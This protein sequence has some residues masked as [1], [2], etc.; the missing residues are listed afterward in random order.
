MSLSVEDILAPGGLVAEHLDNYESRPEQLEMACAVASAFAD[1]EHLL[2]EA[3]TGVGKSFAYLA[4]AILQATA[5]TKRRVVVSTYTIALQEQLITKDLPFLSEIYPKKF[6]AVLG[7]G[8][9]NY[10]CVRRLQRTIAAREKLLASRRHQEQLDDLAE[11]A[12]E[13][14]SGSLQDIE[15]PL[16]RSVWSRCRAE[17][18]LCRNTQCER[19]ENCFFRAARRRMQGADVLVVNHALFFSDL[20]LQA[21]AARM[22]GKYDLVVLDEAHT[23]EQVAGDHFGSSISSSTVNFLL[24][25][26]YNDRTN[27]GTLAAIGDADSIQAVNRASVAAEAFFE[28]LADAR[29]RD[30]S[31]SGRIRRPDIVPN[32]LTAALAEVAAA[33]KHLARQY[34]EDQAQDLLG[35]AQR[36]TEQ[37][38][39]VAKLISQAEADHAYWVQVRRA[40]PAPVVTLASAPIDVS[41]MVRK[42]L[43]DEV[44]SAVLTSATLATGRG[45][46]HGFDYIRSRLGLEEGRDLLLTSPFDFR[47][48]ARLYVETQLGDPND[49]A[50]FA[51]AAARAI[52]HYVDQ[53]QGRCFVLL[54]SYKMLDAV[55]EEI[56]AFCMSEGYRILAQG[57][58]LPRSAMLKEFRRNPRS[59]LL[60][61]ASFW[62]GV[63]VVGEALGNV[64]ITKLPFAAPD[65]PIIEARIEA[66]RAG[67][68]NAFGHFQLPEAIIRFKQGFGRLIRSQTDLGIVVVLDHRIVTKS[69]GKQFLQAL[70]DVEVVYDEFSGRAASGDSDV[71]DDLWEYT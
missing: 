44:T 20:A 18:G 12:M 14:R 42:L 43:F 16:D 34:E 11:W 39:L 4:P 31:R 51:P 48:Q 35:L 55:D 54:T 27:R 33:V 47:R 70:P 68:G 60:G 52:E 22:L 46:A 66:I 3:G 7:K 71:P 57:R 61:T 30:V 64:I 62:Q 67:G 6:T 49:L 29:G 21:K 69:Y 37:A 10:L 65:S 45:A 63:D 40:K 58:D 53:S 36:A 19:Y 2:V 23:V 32:T 41:P 9:G 17:A 15:F 5:K 1:K 59:V 8:R 26:L 25:E 56:T 50:G 13:T 24:R 28:A 38:V